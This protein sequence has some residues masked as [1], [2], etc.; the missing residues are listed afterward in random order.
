MATFVKL[1]HVSGTIKLD[2]WALKMWFIFENISLIFQ[3]M[4]TVIILN[5]K[6]FYY[7]SLVHEN[8][9]D[10]N[11]WHPKKRLGTSRTHWSDRRN[12]LKNSCSFRTF[13]FKSFLPCMHGKVLW[14]KEWMYLISFCVCNIFIWFSIRTF[15]N[16]GK[17]MQRM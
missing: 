16:R 7:S 17:F 11:T 2:Q 1:S 6:M 15:L 13:L 5:V 8:R 3:K 9:A 12:P 14:K 10:K 4:L